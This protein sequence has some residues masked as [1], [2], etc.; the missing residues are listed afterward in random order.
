MIRL[1]V[2]FAACAHV[3]RVPAIARSSQ[4]IEAAVLSVESMCT[5]RDPF[6]GQMPDGIGYIAGS[7][8]IVDDRHAL[9]ALHV[10]D[11]FAM[12]AVRV[13]MA[14]GRR[15]R[16]VVD[17][18]DR[19]HDLARMVIMSDETFGLGA[20]VAIGGPIIGEPACTAVAHPRRQVN[21]GEVDVIWPVT[22][23][24]PATYPVVSFGVTQLTQRGNSG[25]GTY[26]NGK[27]IGVTIALQK[28]VDGGG[29]VVPVGGV[30]P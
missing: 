12:H 30:W 17:K 1:L 15:L 29:M 22:R 4:Q 9:T 14:N 10:V 3:P 21:C 27:L 5:N 18:I 23:N 24:G 6:A 7:G 8:V 28:D 25:S 16:M 2:L 13:Q 26:Q 19:P 11:C 20:G